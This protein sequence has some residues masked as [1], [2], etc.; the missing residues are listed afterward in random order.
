[1]N[2]IPRNFDFIIAEAQTDT[3]GA[4]KGDWFLVTRDDRGVLIGTNSRTHIEYRMF[5]D[6]LRNEN[7]YKFVRVA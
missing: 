4:N 7:Y 6:H 3:N 5:A 2:R 1:M